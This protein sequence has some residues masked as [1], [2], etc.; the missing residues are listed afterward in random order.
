MIN[1]STL[2]NTSRPVRKVQ[3]V[4]RGL[5]SG[6]GKT[7]T[8]G[9]KGDKSRCGYKRRYGHEGGQMRLYRKSPCRGFSN[10]RF[11][12]PVYSINLDM[13]DFLFKDGEVVNAESL[14]Q[15]GYAPRRMSGGLKI[16]SNGELTKKVSI[17]ANS[18][19]KAAVEKLEK[20]GITFKTI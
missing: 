19:S 15:K 7:C 12:L 17:E 10:E 13:I 8:R 2:K 9:N 5:G 1:L 18:Y 20:Q 6:R 3:R 4:G 11:Q 16:L 14:R